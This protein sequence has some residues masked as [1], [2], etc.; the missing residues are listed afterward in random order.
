MIIKSSKEM[1][2]SELYEYVHRLKSSG[3]HA[4]RYE[5]DLHDKLAFP[6]SS[7]VMV[8]IAT[9]L[10][11]LRVR[12]GGAGRG[13]TLT[14]LIAFA[15]WSVMSIGMT[16]GRSGAVPPALSAWFANILFI[17]ASAFILHRMNRSR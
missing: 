1:S 12:S 4:A 14:V 15:Y 17:S 7:L 8:L 11:L 10:S 6:F 13:I 3:Y 9:P 2:F 5:V 16:L